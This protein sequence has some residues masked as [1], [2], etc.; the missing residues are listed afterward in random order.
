MTMDAIFHRNTVQNNLRNQN[1][2]NQ[3]FIRTIATVLH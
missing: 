1:T 2:R 3:F